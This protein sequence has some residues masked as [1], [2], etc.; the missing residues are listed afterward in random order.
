MTFK[1]DYGFALGILAIGL[2]YI[3]ISY[4]GT[5][6]L[7]SHGPYL[8]MQDNPLNGHGLYGIGT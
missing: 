4:L 8:M 6:E 7:A 5:L 2:I 3:L 1:E